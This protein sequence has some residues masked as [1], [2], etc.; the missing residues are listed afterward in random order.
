MINS[1]DEITFQFLKWDS[2]QLGFPCGIIDCSIFNS[3]LSQLQMI[4]RINDLI[5]DHSKVKFITLKISCFY[6]ELL[7]NFLKKDNFKLIDTE[8]IFKR[9]QLNKNNIKVKARQQEI[10]ISHANRIDANFFLPLVQELKWSRFYLDNR[11]NRN[12]AIHL[13]ENSLKNHFSGRADDIAVAYINNKPA[14]LI[15]ITKTTS[16]SIT[17][18]LVGVLN[19]FK[20]REVG[21]ALLNSVSK[22][23]QTISNIFVETSCQNIPAQK[24]YQKNGYIVEN[25]KHIIHIIKN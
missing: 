5:I 1:I 12:K 11:I 3:N 8:L 13:W 2:E 7:N 18:F 23:Y 14:G 22:K 17:L 19:E 4:N 24:L 6:N 16:K 9:K 25:I 15:L 10:M 21:T 20:R